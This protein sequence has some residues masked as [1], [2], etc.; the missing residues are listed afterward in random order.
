MLPEAEELLVKAWT[1]EN[2]NHDGR[3]W[4]AVFPSLR[5]QPYQKP[6][7]PLVRACISEDSVAE[8]AKI[9]RPILIGIQAVDTLRHRLQLYHDT[10]LEAGFAEEAVED[11]LGPDLGAAGSVHRGERPRSAG[12]S[13]AR[14]REVP[15]TP[16]AG[17][18][19]VQPWRC[20]TQTPG[21]SP[22]SQRSCGDY[23]FGRHAPEGDRADCRA[24]GRGG[25]QPPA[26]HERRADTA[27]ASGKINASLR[28]EGASGVPR[29]LTFTAGQTTYQE[30]IQQ[31]LKRSL[32]VLRQ[33]QRLC[34][35]CRSDEPISRTW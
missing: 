11:A 22:A 18:D 27:A 3:F 24:Q 14:P 4:K 8:M 31:L 29:R 7:P 5:P 19:Q 10:M 6:H 26:Q 34:R 23:L 21:P 25:A 16:L 13:D 28:G 32:P 15:G 12:S 9:G 30:L 35:A 33:A 1:G 20:A 2:I 17:P